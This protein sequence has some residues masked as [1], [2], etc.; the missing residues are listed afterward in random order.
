MIF[1]LVPVLTIITPFFI[2]LFPS[3]FGIFGDSIPGIITGLLTSA[4]VT[5]LL[6]NYVYNKNQQIEL[7]N[8]LKSLY[9]EILFNRKQLSKFEDEAVRIKKYW[10]VLKNNKFAQIQWEIFQSD[11]DNKPFSC[12][13]TLV[14]HG[15]SWISPK[16][17]SSRQ[18]YQDSRYLYQ[19]LSDNVFQAFIARGHHLKINGCDRSG[20]NNEWDNLSLL[21]KHFNEFNE[22]TQK[23]EDNVSVFLGNVLNWVKNHNYPCDTTYNDL[24][25]LFF[26]TCE[27]YRI[28]P[29]NLKK[30]SY[31]GLGKIPINDPDLTLQGQPISM[32]ERVYITS[33]KLSDEVIFSIPLT[34]EQTILPYFIYPYE[35]P[36]TFTEYIDRCNEFLITSG[37]IQRR[38][39]EKY[40]VALFQ[41]E[42]IDQI[43]PFKKWKEKMLVKY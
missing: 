36:V 31:I 42:N 16:G 13:E 39:I 24:Q 6:I 14:F 41:S 3:E 1:L 10:A 35:T 18:T 22:I 5:I 4:I 30:T 9:L 17:V 32:E 27:G 23:I 11:F 26:I 34:E 8:S 25:S 12:V 28:V 20:A 21:Y 37:D 7:E 15:K 33:I 38:E 43:P 2:L 40:F 19:F 29:L